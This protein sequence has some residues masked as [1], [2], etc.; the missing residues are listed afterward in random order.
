MKILLI[1]CLPGLVFACKTSQTSDIRSM[2]VKPSALIGTA[3]DAY[4]Q[5]FTGMSCLDVTALH[6]GDYEMTPVRELNRNMDQ[7]LTETDLEKIFGSFQKSFY[8]P[9]TGLRLSRPFETVQRIMPDD[10]EAVRL[11]TVQSQKGA[12][13]F[14]LESHHKLR[15]TPEAQKL[16][17]QILVASEKQRPQRIQAFVQACGTGFLSGTRFVLGMAATLRWIFKS[18]EDR[19]RWGNELLSR[20]LDELM[21]G[22]RPPMQARL[23]YESFIKETRDINARRLG[24]IGSK[25]CPP[26]FQDPCLDAFRLFMSTG[27]PTY[28]KAV[29]RIP[30][31]SDLILPQAY[32]AEPEITRYQEIEPALTDLPLEPDARDLAAWTQARARFVALYVQAFKL[33]QRMDRMQ[34]SP[35]EGQRLHALMQEISNAAA[36][37]YRPILD[38]HLCT[39]ASQRLA[40]SLPGELRAAFHDEP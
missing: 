21:D 24:D 37:C 18:A 2:S 31:N 35:E 8:A 34:R 6:A 5:E 16:V 17:Q 36:P 33:L 1:G 23:R 12:L 38:I 32:L 14:R 7:S 10:R 29:R 13:R 15:L 30:E 11:V 26:D 20:E 19:Q 27:I 39:N 28:Q 25:D 22:Q 9:A 40:Q 3:Y 4:T